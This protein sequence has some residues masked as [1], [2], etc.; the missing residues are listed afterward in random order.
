MSSIC[1]V[2]C[3]ECSIKDKCKGSLRR[4]IILGEETA[5]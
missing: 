3:N 4:M 1:G 5:Y 2:N